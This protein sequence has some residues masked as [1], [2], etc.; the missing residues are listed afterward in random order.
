MKL[1]TELELNSEDVVFRVRFD[2]FKGERQYFDAVAGV[3][4]PGFD[5]YVCINE[6]NFGAGWEAPEAYP[7]LDIIACE[8][9]VIEKLSELEAAEQ[10]ERDEWEQEEN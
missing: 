9:E 4:S 8:A 5:A 10:V 1:P 2:Y 3:G 7:Q 6:V